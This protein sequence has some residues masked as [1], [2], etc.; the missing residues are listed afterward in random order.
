MCPNEIPASRGLARFY[1]CKLTV[2]T[3]I[4]MDVTIY[5]HMLYLLAMALA[6]NHGIA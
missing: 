2:H 4:V 3:K 5:V 1:E 6:L